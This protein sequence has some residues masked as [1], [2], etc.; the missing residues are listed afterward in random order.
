LTQMCQ[1]PVSTG[2]PNTVSH[3]DVLELLV[4]P[5]VFN[6]RCEIEQELRITGNAGGPGRNRATMPWAVMLRMDLSAT[7]LR[8]PAHRTGGR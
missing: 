7:H 8:P 2:E 1:L 3:Q 5:K 6:K 4:R